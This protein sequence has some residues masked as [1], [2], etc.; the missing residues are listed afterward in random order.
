MHHVLHELLVQNVWELGLYLGQWGLRGR[1]T[2]DEEKEREREVGRERE[3]EGGDK[4]QPY[5]NRV[6][7]SKRH[8]NNFQLL[9]Q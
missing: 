4:Q 8:L 2:C 9:T 5:S 3:R 7:T 1:E 6:L